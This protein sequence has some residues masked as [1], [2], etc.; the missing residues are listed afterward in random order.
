MISGRGGLGV[1]G[2]VSRLAVDL[3]SAALLELYFVA[4]WDSKTLL[5][6]EREFVGVF[7]ASL[8]LRFG[9]ESEEGDRRVT[10]LVSGWFG[11]A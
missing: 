11:Y 3:M 9:E 2:L 1:F 6:C 4:Q 5:T 7:W 8:T 10:L